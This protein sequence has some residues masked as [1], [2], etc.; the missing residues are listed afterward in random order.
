MRLVKSLA[1]GLVAAVAAM[2]GAFVV[3]ALAGNLSV[4]LDR[5]QGGGS[6]GFYV[7]GLEIPVLTGL[8]GGIAGFVWQWRRGRREARP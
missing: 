2:I 4:W 1:V 3:L 5:S 7:A 8:V 6:G